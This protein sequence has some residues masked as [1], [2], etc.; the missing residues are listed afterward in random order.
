MKRSYKII[1]VNILQNTWSGREG[2][3]EPK[4][5]P[6]MWNMHERVLDGEQRTN[7]SVEGQYY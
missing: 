2:F 5:P 6:I 1:I 3:V 7:N 4:F